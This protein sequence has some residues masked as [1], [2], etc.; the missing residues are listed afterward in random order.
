MGDPIKDGINA[1]AEASPEIEGD[2][3]MVVHYVTV[4]AL[5]RLTGSGVES[6]TVLLA[7]ADQPDYVSE[8]LLLA[9]DRLQS[10]VVE[11]HGLPD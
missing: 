4:A 9:A 10:A 6:A 1:A 8:G 11:D 5:Q 3:W 7:A 2:G